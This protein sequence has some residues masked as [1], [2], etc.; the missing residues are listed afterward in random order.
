[1]Y[2][3]KDCRRH[4]MRSVYWLIICNEFIS[5]KTLQ[6]IEYVVSFDSNQEARVSH[7]CYAVLVVGFAQEPPQSVTPLKE[8]SSLQV[9]QLAALRAPVDQCA[10]NLIVN[11]LSTQTY[12]PTRRGSSTTLPPMCFHDHIQKILCWLK[13]AQVRQRYFISTIL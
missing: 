5:I 11:L 3:H 7:T 8:P 13:K 2:T 1:M 9:Q 12:I 10:G 4:R 6:Y